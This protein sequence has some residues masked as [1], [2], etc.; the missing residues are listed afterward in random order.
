MLSKYELGFVDVTTKN[1]VILEKLEIIERVAKTDSFLLLQGE[2]GA[3]KGVFAELIHRKSQRRGKPFFRVN[4]AALSEELLECAL[5]GGGVDSKQGGFELAGG[6]TVFFDEIGALPLSIQS[7]LLLVIQEKTFKKPSSDSVISTDARI[8]ASTKM[9]I[10]SKIEKGEF[11]RDLYFR[12]NVFPLYI[13]PLRQRLEDLPDL[14][15][16]FLGINNK[17]SSNQ[18]EGFS[19]EA[20][21]TMLSYSW[22]GNIRELKNCIRRACITGKGKTIEAEDLFLKQS[23]SVEMSEDGSRNLKAAEN[24][25]RTRYIKQ[26]LEENRGNQTETAKALNIQRTYLS[27]LIKELDIFVSKE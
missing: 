4:C 16:C 17:D 7:K 21:E 18:F 13:P 26:V 5:F 8:I 10:E 6:G 3:G 2:G 27:R 11:N 23:L 12:L 19:S 24:I 15:A 20:M 25:F 22:P 9:D 1:P 14:A